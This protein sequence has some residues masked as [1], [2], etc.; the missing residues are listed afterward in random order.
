MDKDQQ[1]MRFLA[2]CFTMNGLVSNGI[3]SPKKAVELADALIEELLNEN[4]VNGG[5]TTIVPKRKR[6]NNIRNT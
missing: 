1:H 2:S 5:I 6:R 3:E 4:V